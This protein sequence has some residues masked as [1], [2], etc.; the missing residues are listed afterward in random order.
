M[1]LYPKRDGNENQNNPS[2]DAALHADS[3]GISDV[4]VL[5]G[6]ALN[7]IDHQSAAGLWEKVYAHRLP[8]MIAMPAQNEIPHFYKNYPNIIVKEAKQFYISNIKANKSP[9]NYFL[10][11]QYQ[12]YIIDGGRISKEALELYKKGSNMNDPFCMT[13]IA[14]MLIRDN[15]AKN[16]SKIVYFLF[17]SFIKTSIE[18]YNFLNANLIVKYS[19][20]NGLLKERNT[21]GYQVADHSEFFNMD[22][23]WYLCYYF[24]SHPEEFYSALDKAVKVEKCS[25]GFRETILFIFKNLH[26]PEEHVNILKR[27]EE[28]SNKYLD[29]KAAFHFCMFSFLI[30]KISNIPINI[31]YIISVLKF[32]ADDGNV[33]ACERL[34]LY[35]DSK[36]D[37]SNAFF[38]F[39]KA[40]EYYLPLSLE[41]L[42]NYYCSFKNSFKTINLKLANENWQRATYLGMFNSIEYLKLLDINKDYDRLFILANFY[43]SSGLFGSELILGECF[44]KGKG[45]GKNLYLAKIFYKKGLQQHR[46][47][48][49]FLYRMARIIEKETLSNSNSDSNAGQNENIGNSESTL[50][51]PLYH[52]FY[53]VCYIIYNNLFQE[54][55]HNTNNMWIL[56]AYRLASLYACGRGVTKD[57][58]RSINFLD[59]ILSANIT[60]E[61]SSYVCLYF[62]ILAQKKRK[63]FSKE[64][65]SSII[66]LSNTGSNV[67]HDESVSLNVKDC[68]NSGRV[69]TIENI[70]PIGGNVENIPN[71]NSNNQSSLSDG[72]IQL[73]NLVDSKEQKN[74]MK[75]NDSIRMMIL[76][77]EKKNIMH[78][79]MPMDSHSQMGNSI[80]ISQHKSIVIKE[81]LKGNLN[82]NLNSNINGNSI[83]SFTKSTANNDR[84]ATK[85]KYT[86]EGI[87]V[88]RES[89][90]RLV[91][92]TEED[93]KLVSHEIEGVFIK[94]ISKILS[95]SK[96]LAFI[97]GYLENIKKN[98]VKIID[99]NDIIFDEVV[100]NGGYSK[101]FS[102][103][104]NNTRIAVKE[105]KNVSETT[106]KKILEEI[107][108]QVSLKSERINKVLY[109]AVDTAPLKI[110]SVN[111]FMK[112][113]LR[114]VVNSQRL[115][116]VQKCFI[117][118]Q[119]L[120]A[121]LYLHDQC[122]PIVHRDLKPENILIDEKFNIELCDFG[123]FKILETNKTISETLNRFY[124][125]RYSPPEVIKNSRFICKAS[126]IWSVG[127]ILYDI[128]YEQQ[129]WFGLSSEEIVDSIKKER[130]F[131]VKRDK[132][133]PEQITSIIKLCTQYEYAHR[134]KA[135][136]IFNEVINMIY[137]LKLV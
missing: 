44:E 53:R 26:K 121:V 4:E 68:V 35:C 92:D 124:T 75:L 25:D 116:L 100:G 98:G 99:V 102:G 8:P 97:E 126:D 19:V 77:N 108:L 128:F 31:D 132:S 56:D 5:L 136:D 67:C 17:R 40:A 23:F 83:F 9:I 66:S 129:P 22:S 103:W 101:V 106:A 1:N 87:S 58:I 118:K 14:E 85:N 70:E 13:K 47:G 109:L 93:G 69:E 127:L 11:G 30:I 6:T 86:T 38:Y 10:L 39:T 107:N 61:T 131:Q 84:T 24:D 133:V 28:A 45:V 52:D 123:V 78:M 65:I 37:Y 51:K 12:E 54:D 113:N 3:A 125:V 76:N 110:C 29:K 104:Y 34:G 112:H 46:E 48:C 135:Q 111:K 71:F 95:G 80:N 27:L 33:F 130:P 62:H 88:N 122:P 72:K 49:G 64:N 81:N 55:K 36:M 20:R 120:E 96:E 32:L 59:Y 18:P 115:S 43:Y 60:Q 89:L 74:K 134:P 114:I 82:I 137:E 41:Y 117:S 90:P 21:N 42:G 57:L 73:E 7:I 105:F 119:L 50:S 79:H 2:I 63:L 15:E 16:R 94:H 91:M